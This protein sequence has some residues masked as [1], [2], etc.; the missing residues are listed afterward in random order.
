[1]ENKYPFFG[2]DS[3]K[4]VMVVRNE[5][6][7]DGVFDRKIDPKISRLFIS[8][9]TLSGFGRKSEKKHDF[10]HG[11]RARGSGPQDTYPRRR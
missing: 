1:M 7:V 3:E 2:S 11:V 5:N 6:P 10:F 8:D 9:P 4:T